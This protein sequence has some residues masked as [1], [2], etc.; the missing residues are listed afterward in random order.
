MEETAQRWQVQEH[1]EAVRL[2]VPF[3]VRTIRL[4][5]F[6]PDIVEA[7]RAVNEPSGLSLTS[8]TKVRS[9]IWAEQRRDL[10]FHE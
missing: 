3:V 1:T 9:E 6:A 10:G 8:L 7:I 4:T 2:D 5:F